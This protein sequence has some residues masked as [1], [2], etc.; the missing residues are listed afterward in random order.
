MGETK[1]KPKRV[2][3]ANAHAVDQQCHHSL[4]PLFNLSEMT[5]AAALTVEKEKASSGAL[6]STA[7]GAGRHHLESEASSNNRNHQPP[8]IGLEAT[9][10][11][12]NV[13]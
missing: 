13:W 4:K 3:T 5:N 2:T 9:S 1:G 11:S 10:Q 6:P 8:T 7:R 12:D